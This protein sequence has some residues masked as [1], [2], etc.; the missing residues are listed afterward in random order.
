NKTFGNALISVT[1][2]REKFYRRTEN[3]ALFELRILK[4]AIHEIGHTIGLEHCP[5]FCVMKFSNDLEDT[6]QKPPKF[7]EECANI[8]DIF[9]DNYE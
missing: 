7:C 2:L 4:E 8:M 5:N 1:R 6:D 9:I 3:V